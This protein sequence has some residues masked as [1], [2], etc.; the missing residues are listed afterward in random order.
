MEEVDRTTKT[1]EYQNREL[2]EKVKY[3]ESELREKMNEL[4]MMKS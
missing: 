4:K 2:G 1:I 3:D